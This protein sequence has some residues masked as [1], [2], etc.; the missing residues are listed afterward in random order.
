MAPAKRPLRT[1]SRPRTKTAAKQAEE[2]ADVQRRLKH[3]AAERREAAAANER[4]LSARARRTR[5]P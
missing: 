5:T 3:E 4:S 2:A 1:D